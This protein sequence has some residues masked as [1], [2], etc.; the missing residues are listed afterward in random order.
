MSSINLDVE[1]IQKQA[2]EQAVGELVDGMHEVVKEAVR[3][4]V[5]NHFAET[6]T[7]LVD[8]AI[9]SVVDQGM[10][11]EFQRMDKWGRP[12]DEP[13]TTIAKI[14]EEQ[15]Q[16]Y[17][18]CIVNPRTGEKHSY[19]ASKCTRAEYLVSRAMGETFK[20]LVE[21]QAI[22]AAGQFKDQLRD[23][24]AKSINATVDNLIKVKSLGDQKGKT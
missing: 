4:E 1:A 23:S 18:G 6:A 21:Q 3:N 8:E 20:E 14:L 10:H 13:P 7:G 5:S 15:S 24:L 19:G 12:G 16:N 2:I 17:W 9:Q 22:N 11:A